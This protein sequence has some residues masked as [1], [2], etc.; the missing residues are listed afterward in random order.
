MLDEN[1]PN[2]IF[3]DRNREGSRYVLG[4]L[5]AAEAGVAPLHLDH[6]TNELF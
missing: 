6:R 4:N 5:P 2:D 1:A 3:I